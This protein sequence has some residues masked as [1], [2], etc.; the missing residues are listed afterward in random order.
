[1]VT[2][3]AGKI[4]RQIAFKRVLRKINN[5]HQLSITSTKVQQVTKKQISTFQGF[6]VSKTG[7]IKFFAAA[8]QGKEFV[9][10]TL[11]RH[12]LH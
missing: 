4:L 3:G 2:T 1:V 12:L 9:F 8:F 7:A 6:K 11:K 10:E 5:F